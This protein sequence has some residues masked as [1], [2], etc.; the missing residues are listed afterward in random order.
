MLVYLVYDV[1]LLRWAEL[2]ERAD[3]YVFRCTC[4]E[5]LFVNFSG[6]ELG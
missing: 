3:M 5:N 4:T 1:F 2:L 6:I